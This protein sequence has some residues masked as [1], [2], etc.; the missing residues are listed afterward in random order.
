[1]LQRNL[2]YTGVTRGRQARGAG[3][4]AEGAGDRGGRPA[5]ATPLVEAER[6]AGRA[7]IMLAFAARSARRLSRRSL[8][9]NPWRPEAGEAK[10]GRTFTSRRPWLR[11]G[12]CLLAAIVLL[13][14]YA[15]QITE[16]SAVARAVPAAA[17]VLAA[18]PSVHGAARGG[19][20]CPG[21]ELAARCRSRRRGLPGRGDR[22]WRPRRLA[23][24]CV[25]SQVAGLQRHR[26]RRSASGLA[27][28]AHHGRVGRGPAVRRAAAGRLPVA[29][30]A[31]PVP[32]PQPRLL[33]E[34]RRVRRDP[35][36]GRGA[37]IGGRLHRRGDVHL[38]R[39]GKGPAGAL[40]DDGRR[41]GRGN[42]RRQPIRHRG[43]VQRIV[44]DDGEGVARNAAAQFGISGLQRGRVVVRHDVPPGRRARM[45]SL[46]HARRIF[47]LGRVGRLAGADHAD[48]G[49]H[50]AERFA[51]RARPRLPPRWP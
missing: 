23:G 35:Q 42:A 1:M 48:W 6:V 11:V 7:G 29:I 31:R 47:P 25:G 26:A 40:D 39:S 43:A 30:P 34:S 37:R 50:V 33:Q 17:F 15:H 10:L 44:H 41:G 51:C 16:T 2:L 20:G 49:R 3:R 9:L 46:A 36:G 22:A 24:P 13:P 5:G 27:P 19:G 32:L 4:P 28:V 12:G 38:D 14:L 45:E 8:R 21:I 18:R